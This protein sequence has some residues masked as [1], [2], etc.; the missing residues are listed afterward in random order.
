MITCARCGW[1]IKQDFG[2]VDAYGEPKC[3]DGVPHTPEKSVTKL[4]PKSA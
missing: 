4:L 3:I 1:E 2:W